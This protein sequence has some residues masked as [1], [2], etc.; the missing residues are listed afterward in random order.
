MTMHFAMNNQSFKAWS[1]NKKKHPSIKM[2]GNDISK[3]MFFS[4]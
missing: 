4:I 1:E 2:P 3:E